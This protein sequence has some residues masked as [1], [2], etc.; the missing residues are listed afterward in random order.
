MVNG[1]VTFCFEGVDED[2]VYSAT[3]RIIQAVESQCPDL[4]CA[5]SEDTWEDEVAQ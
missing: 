2:A 1:V 5:V 3:E 4:T